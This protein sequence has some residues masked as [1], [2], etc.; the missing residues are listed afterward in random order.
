[1]KRLLGTVGTISI[2]A[3]VLLPLFLHGCQHKASTP[4]PP[5]KVEVGSSMDTKLRGQDAVATGLACGGSLYK[6]VGVHVLP[7]NGRVLDVGPGTPA[8]KAGIKDMDVILNDDILG[9]DRYPVGT[10]LALRV[11]RGG[12]VIDIN[13]IVEIICNEP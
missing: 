4:P 1:M 5:V 13:V 6:G 3:A 8:E 9:T 10:V 12:V 7:W 2:H 11:L